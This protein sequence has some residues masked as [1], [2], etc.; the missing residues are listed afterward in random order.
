MAQLNNASCLTPV[1]WTTLIL[2]KVA[3]FYGIFFF[4]F[5]LLQFFKKLLSIVFSILHVSQ[6]SSLVLCFP[7]KCTQEIELLSSHGIHMVKVDINFLLMSHFKCFNDK[8]TRYRCFMS[9][10]NNANKV[11]LPFS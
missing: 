5:F 7:A 9:E 4:L 1:Y 10:H 2:A 11:L 8:I 3:S 6:M